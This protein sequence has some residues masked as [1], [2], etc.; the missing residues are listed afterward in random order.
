M[1]ETKKSSAKDAQAEEVKAAGAVEVQERVDK[2]QE[3]GYAGEVVD[4]IPNKEYSLQSGPDSP[5][6]ADSREALL[7]REAETNPG[8]RS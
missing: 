2:E 7:K 6:A 3:Q 4:P 8:R 1:A 5:T